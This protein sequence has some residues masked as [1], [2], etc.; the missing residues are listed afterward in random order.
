MTVNKYRRKLLYFI[1]ITKQG[2]MHIA[3]ENYAKMGSNRL[4]AGCNG[5]PR[6]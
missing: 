3:A 4:F 5:Y 2:F 6:G 1:K